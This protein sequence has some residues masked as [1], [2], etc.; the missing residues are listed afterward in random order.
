MLPITVT[1]REGADACPVRNV[2][3]AVTGKW[4]L[5]ILL[6]LM[7]GPER[8]SSLKRLIGDVTQRVLTEALRGLEREGYLTREVRPGPP[9]E[10]HYALTPAGREIAELFLPMVSWAAERLPDVIAARARYDAG[11]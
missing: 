4:R 7:D 3:N 10:V 5:L 2:L 9:I 1:T 11:T 8:F 6:A